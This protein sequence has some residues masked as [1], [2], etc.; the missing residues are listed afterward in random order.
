MPPPPDLWTTPTVPVEEKIATSLAVADDG[1]AYVGAFDGN[2]YKVN[3]SGEVEWT[4]EDAGLVMGKAAITG[5]LVIAGANISGSGRQAEGGRVFAL[6]ADKT[7]VW[8]FD[9]EGAV[10]AA[11]ILSEDKTTAYISTYTGHIYALDVQT[12]SQLW[13]FQLPEEQKNYRCPSTGTTKT[14]CAYRRQ[15]GF[16]TE[17]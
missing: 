1:S 2:F 16:C 4:F 9:T 3:A 6:K 10:V 13:H 5:N 12:G 15:A 14:G 17:Y 7:P 8:H 11:P